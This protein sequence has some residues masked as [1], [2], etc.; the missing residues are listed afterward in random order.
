MPSFSKTFEFFNPWSTPNTH[1]TQASIQMPQ[2]VNGKRPDPVLTLFSTAQTAAGYLKLGSRLH[3]VNY[4]VEGSF[5]GTLMLQYSNTPAP[6]ENDWI[7]LA[8]TQKSYN[9]TET[10]GSP[11]IVGFGGAIS[12]P[13]QTD[14]IDFTGEFGWLRVHLDISQGT[15][16][17]VKL[18]F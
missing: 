12:H 5:R 4:S 9:G 3:T 13:T 8:E 7:D 10:T 15:C 16:Q 2:M 6:G 11:S 14:S 1:T 18:N 17:A